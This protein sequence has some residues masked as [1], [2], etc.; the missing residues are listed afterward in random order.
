MADLVIQQQLTVVA[1]AV[2]VLQ[3][4]SPPVAAVAMLIILQA[5]A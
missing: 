1:V 5:S 4:Q 2:A 3:D